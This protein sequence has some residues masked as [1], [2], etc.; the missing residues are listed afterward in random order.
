[1]HKVTPALTLASSIDLA[2]A[3]FAC[4][5]LQLADPHTLGRAMSAVGTLRPD[6]DVVGGRVQALGLARSIGD[7]LVIVLNYDAERLASNQATQYAMHLITWF[8]GDGPGSESVRSAFVTAGVP[9]AIAPLINQAPP[10]DCSFAT[11]TFWMMI[12]AMGWWTLGR[13]DIEALVGHGYIELMAKATTFR[14]T[15][16]LNQATPP[17]DAR[18]SRR[19][20]AVSSLRS[21][22]QR[23]GAGPAPAVQGHRS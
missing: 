22:D 15:R 18:P 14:I 20:L 3:I 16:D 23:S 7:A 4:G 13:S 1:V 12:S 10:D 6:F 21:A 9:A 5:P 17:N 2:L 8:I 11:T 19:T